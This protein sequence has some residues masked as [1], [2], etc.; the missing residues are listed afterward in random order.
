LCAFHISTNL[1]LSDKEA[2]FLD[3]ELS[4][5]DIATQLAGREDSYLSVYDYVPLNLAGNLQFTGAYGR[6]N[7][8]G[9]SYNQVSCLFHLSAQ[10][11]VNPN[12]SAKAEIPSKVGLLTND[13]IDTNTLCHNFLSLPL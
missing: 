4:T 6:M 3:N 7:A 1:A 9:G 13:R 10:V 5:A 11:S 2:A 8:A 12:G